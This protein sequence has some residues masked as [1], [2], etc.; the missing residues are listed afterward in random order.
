MTVSIG[1][2]EDIEQAILSAGPERVVEIKGEVQAKLRNVG[3]VVAS[4]NQSNRED[5]TWRWNLYLDALCDVRL[6][7][8]RWDSPYA[9]ES[10][11]VAM[12]ASELD[13]FADWYDVISAV[14]RSINQRQKDGR[15]GCNEAKKDEFL[16]FVGDHEDGI[17]KLISMGRR[18]ASY[19]NE[20]SQQI[21]RMSKLGSYFVL[22]KI[23]AFSSKYL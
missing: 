6:G 22:D 4:G 17:R 12:T 18:Y 3:T 11:I 15:G 16:R 20:R 5:P 21:V 10:R 8:C 9:G 1:A 23:D 14:A 13:F 2:F 7:A 19:L